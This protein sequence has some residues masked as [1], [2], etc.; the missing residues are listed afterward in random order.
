MQKIISIVP[1]LPPSIDGVGDYALKVAQQLRKDFSIH[2]HFIVSNPLWTGED[3]IDG[4]PITQV[5]DRKPE[6]LLDLLNK[7]EDANAVLLQ[8]V[9]HGYA[10][11]GCPFWLI[12]ALE[13]QKRRNLLPHLAVMFHEIYSMGPGVVPWNTDFWLLPWQ[14]EIAKRLANLSDQNLTS[15]EKYAELLSARTG[16]PVSSIET[17]P[18][19]STIGEPCHILPLSVRR[20]RIVIFGQVGNRKKVYQQIDRLSTFSKYLGIEEILDVGPITENT[21]DRLIDIPIKTVGEISSSE[22]SEILKNSM[23]GVLAY[24]SLRL[25]KSSIFAAYCSHGVL[26]INML[27]SN[28]SLD[29]LQE[30]KHYYTANLLENLHFPSH[31]L[32]EVADNAQ[33]WYSTH[34]YAATA[35]M[36][37]EILLRKSIHSMA[38]KP[39][40]S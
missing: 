7:V 14:K 1:R 29:G 4:F 30:G 40:H 2:T 38:I 39:I 37:S 11:K 10:K 26:P 35:K 9:L 33:N 31:N 12:N 13:E 21:V 19:L 6:V 17:L 16:I 25:A 18:V 23:V 34:N 36:F 8:Y 20:K 32:Q 28:I 24:D 3:N 15:S 27:S 5:S 22:I